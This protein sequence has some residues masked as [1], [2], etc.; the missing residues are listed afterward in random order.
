VSRPDAADGNDCADPR[1]NYPGTSSRSV[2]RGGARAA[3]QVKIND[4]AGEF[5]SD[6]R[7]DHGH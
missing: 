7:A 6:G 3:S 5:K 1:R 4:A 2:L